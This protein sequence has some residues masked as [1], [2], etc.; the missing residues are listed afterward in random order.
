M[1]YNQPLNQTIQNDFNVDLLSS[2]DLSTPAPPLVGVMTQ[3]S[4]R[5]PGTML[6]SIQR[7]LQLN[8]RRGVL[9][10]TNM[11]QSPMSSIELSDEPTYDQRLNCMSQ[12][13]LVDHLQQPTITMFEN[14]A[15]TLDDAVRHVNQSHLMV[16]SSKKR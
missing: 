5:R 4:H 2:F 7:Q 15:S 8:K 3:A 16:R 14:D 11:H 9:S 13:G 1:A 6:R 12:A 10:S